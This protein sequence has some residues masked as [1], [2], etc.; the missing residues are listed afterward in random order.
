MYCR[1]IWSTLIAALLVQ[2]KIAGLQSPLNY[3]KEAVVRS[4]RIS[5][6]DRFG[7]HSFLFQLLGSSCHTLKETASLSSTFLEVSSQPDY[8]TR[9]Q[10]PSINYKRTA[11]PDALNFGSPLEFLDA[12]DN[13][14][15]NSDDDQLLVVKYYANY[16]KACQRASISYKKLAA[17]FIKAGVQFARVEA[18][19][20]WSAADLRPLGVTKFPFVQIYRRGR[21]VASFSTGPS[22][23]FQRVVRETLTTCLQRNVDEWDRLLADFTDEIAENCAARHD[24]RNRIMCS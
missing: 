14:C 23:L 4:S 20:Q 17:E 15:Y 11:G 9:D 24:L 19:T 13:N 21:C 10:E 7:R 16:C 12:L 1:P 3:S 5:N 2:R 18:S 22:H 6:T 8:I